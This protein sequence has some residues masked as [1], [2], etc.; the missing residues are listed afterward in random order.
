MTGRFS[1]ACT[2][3]ASRANACS[4]TSAKSDGCARA[5]LRKVSSHW[6]WVRSRSYGQRTRNM[7]GWKRERHCSCSSAEKLSAV[8]RSPGLTQKSSRPAGV[9]RVALPSNRTHFPRSK[10]SSPNTTSHSNTFA[11]INYSIV[12][13]SGIL[14]PQYTLHSRYKQP[15][16]PAPSLPLVT[17]RGVFSSLAYSHVNAFSCLNLHSL[18]LQVTL[19]PVPASLLAALVVSPRPT[20][21]WK[22]RKQE[23]HYTNENEAYNTY[24]PRPS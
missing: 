15:T 19:P 5:V 22:S 18:T 1:K 17:P 2:S 6:E 3:S 13:Q 16:L 24:P 12:V 4:W 9:T 20:V 23:G 11:I 14:R 21:C 7:N 10:Y 8:L